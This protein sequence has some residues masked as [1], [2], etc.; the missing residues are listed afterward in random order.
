MVQTL[1]LQACWDI[2]DPR[3]V[4]R[5]YSSQG[6]PTKAQ[7]FKSKQCHSKIQLFLINKIENV[8]AKKIWD[9]FSFALQFS[10][11]STFWAA[12]HYSVVLAQGKG[13]M[14]EKV[15]NYSNIFGFNTFFCNNKAQ[16]KS[17]TYYFLRFFEHFSSM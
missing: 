5:I 6:I 13:N 11:V 15:N 10:C 8:K 4:R 9:F 16:S 12:T 17:Y 14:K 2:F 1:V 7:W 3:R